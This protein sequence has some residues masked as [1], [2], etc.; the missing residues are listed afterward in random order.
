MKICE[1]RLI[2]FGPFTDVRIDLSGGKEGLHVIYGPNEA[3]K[4]SALRAL[5]HMLYG[6]PERS[7]DDF[8]HPYTKMR[9][10]AAIQRK[11]GDLLEFVRR[12]GRSNTLR[13][14]DDKTVLDE[15]ILHQFLSGVNADVF[16][17]MFGI[18][19]ADL[20]RGGREIIQGGGSMGQIIFAAGSGVAN[21]REIQ[22][23]LQSEIDFLFK[24]S[25]QKP[26]I[27]E[28]LS[29]LNKSRKELRDA[30]LPSQEWVKHDQALQEAQDRKQAVDQ[31][32][33]HKQRD[34]HRLER[35]REALPIIARRRE[36]I[37]D[38]KNYATAVLLPENFRDERHGLITKLSIAE[39]DRTQTLQVIET[40]KRDM[41]KLQVSE[42]LIEN[43]GL[44][45]EIHQELGSH[46]KAARDRI[47]L[48]TRR[49]ILRS[50]AREILR[51]LRDDL[52]LEDAEKLRIKKADKVGIQ[53]LG[54]K[55]ERIIT[56]IENA[57]E[58]IPKISDQIN[59]L[60]TQL[61][62]LDE[63]KPIDQLKIAI[64]QAEE[65][66][67]LE[68][69]WR[70]DQTEIRND[71]KTLEIKLSKQ[72]LWAGSIEEIEGLRIP[73]LETIDE[74]DD[75]TDKAERTAA[76]LK[77][78]S[79][80]LH[81]AQAEIE[82]QIEQ[83]QLEQ[84]VPTE[85]DLQD[86]RDAR[87]QG[88]QLVRSTIKGDS[89][90]DEEVQD[91]IRRFQPAITLSDAFEASVYQTDEIAD[92]LR[93]EADRVANL[94][95]LIAEKVAQEKQSKRLKEDLVI[96]EKKLTEINNEWAK[97][98]EVTGITP[99]TP[100]EMRGWTQ[101]HAAMTEKAAEI[102]ER[103]S[104]TDALQKSI[105]KRRN[106]LE[107]SLH[108]LSEPRTVRDELL[109]DLIKRARIVIE[110]QEELIN[111]R[112]QFQGE[113]KQKEK[114]LAEAK[115][116]VEQSEKDLSQWKK[117]WEPAVRPLGLVV[118]SK[119]SQANAVMDDLSSLF[120]KLK[121]AET[122][123][124]R[125]K[126]I[127]LD[128]TEFADKV[129]GLV[130]TVAQEL[131][132]L[133]VDQAAT[134]LNARLNRARA[135]QT[136]LQAFE[137]QLS[138][139]Q[140]RDN[141]ANKEMTRIKTRLKGMCEEAG[142]KS[143]EGLPEAERRSEKR[144][145]IESDLKSLDEQ[146]LKLS[147]GDTID[148]FVKESL[149]EDPDGIDTEIERLAEEIDKLTGERSDQDQTIGS[150]RTE[151]SKMDGS[152][153]AADIAEQ[154]QMLLGRLENDVE[155]YARLRLASTMLNQAIERYREKNQAPILKRANSFFAQMTRGS[156]EGVRADFDDN[157][158]PVLVGVRP[159][160]KEVVGVEG[161]SEGTADQLYLV[162]RLA[163]LEEYLEQ[164]EPIPFIVD[165][166]LI[167]FDDDRAVA[168]L[169]ALARLSTRTQVI[170]FTH[171][172]HMVE[173]AEENIDPSVL[174]KHTLNA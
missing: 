146:L 91:F 95:R 106:A 121:E 172:R 43:S 173:L 12:K 145:R 46:R 8:L 89:V 35:I 137:K 36:L 170:F 83:L 136:K 69:R 169:K 102:R 120:E 174:I 21:L 74:F 65:Y 34:R 163:G 114:E 39:N 158:Q 100:R 160:G 76:E 151:L 45:E 150:E 26:K 5:R 140:K 67:V 143:Y 22:Q 159:G 112:K 48:Q 38:Y 135:N 93:R 18:A 37:E 171:H 11:D 107:Q 14:V 115:A 82:Q 99:R 73:S 98:W 147:A 50:E 20:V 109:A 51:D 134:E 49:D 52:T 132:D 53:E 131:A 29:K 152:A 70:E 125:I 168:A 128:S 124:K 129:T 138:K 42:G 19:H 13:A 68:N 72:S 142:C 122:L 57:R 104:K 28:A 56:R 144:R 77:S 25:G 24:P 30:Q 15:S 108:S 155:Q 33:A 44:I 31:E 96:A 85:E 71:V 105:D 40:L 58:A 123:Q 148:D 2:A 110:R 118:D 165:D 60:D 9:V 92:R 17:T 103:K 139:E 78:E 90:P 63:P 7:L 111:I 116:R 154:T 153:R 55:F 119:P 133:P 10:G 157:G 3:G 113:K 16:S 127:D 87:E 141:Q 84:E 164:N 66:G 27:N 80:R 130:K 94:A 54:I 88:W 62:T 61:K 97:L 167:K 64:E 156:F 81:G 162:L 23:D 149:N 41:A 79:K 101:D 4:S 1:I 6:I 75:R 166:I 86:L 126:G 161:M 32:L 117:E 47:R 59:D